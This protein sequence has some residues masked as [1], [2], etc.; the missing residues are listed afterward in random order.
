V[1]GKTSDRKTRRSLLRAD[2][3]GEVYMPKALMSKTRKKPGLIEP[4]DLD[5]KVRNQRISKS[6][7]QCQAGLLL[8][9]CILDAIV[10][11]GDAPK[12]VVEF[13]SFLRTLEKRHPPR[14]DDEDQETLDAVIQAGILPTLQNEPVLAFA[15]ATRIWALG[16]MRDDYSAVR[17]GCSPT[18]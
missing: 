14:L 1:N 7:S 6:K 15:H 4:V 10:E 2:N 9:G 12:E 11:N 18:S 8:V 16:E 17:L 5:A 13:S 3:S